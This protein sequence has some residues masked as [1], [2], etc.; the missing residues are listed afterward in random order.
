M[1]CKAQIKRLG[2]KLDTESRI[3]T[4]IV[5]KLYDGDVK[6]LRELMEMPLEIEIHALQVEFGK[7]IPPKVSKGA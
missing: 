7:G 6:Q 2:V 1:K 5:V 3:V 4:E